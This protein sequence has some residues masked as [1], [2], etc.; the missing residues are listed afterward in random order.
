MTFETFE[1]P[2]AAASECGLVWRTADSCHWGNWR[3]ESTFPG[4]C[5]WNGTLFWTFI[6]I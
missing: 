5:P 2:N 1:R 6:A 4:L 3:M